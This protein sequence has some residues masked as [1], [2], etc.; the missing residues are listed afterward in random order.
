MFILLMSQVST[1]I[2]CFMGFTIFSQDYYTKK[3]GNEFKFFGPLYLT[4]TYCNEHM[5]LSVKDQAIKGLVVLGV[6]IKKNI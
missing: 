4:T 6:R 5:V 1:S 2:Y 3:F